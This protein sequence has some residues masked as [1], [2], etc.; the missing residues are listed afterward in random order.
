M[1][2][3][4]ILTALIR[5]SLPTAPLHGF[6]APA[7]GT[8]KSLLVDLASLIAT[9]HP[10]PVIAQGKSEEEMEKRLGAAL[11]AGDGLI[12]IDNCEQPLRGELLCQ[13]IS[14]TSLKVRILGKSMNAEVPS[15]AAIFATGNNLTLQG[16][17]TR[18]AVRATLDAG[19]ER[20][21]LRAFDRDPAAMVTAK[22]G[23]YVTASLT[24]LRAYHIAGRP[25]QTTPL[26]SFVDWSRWVRDALVWLG[27]A[28]PCETMESVR[29]SDPKLE[30]LTTVLTQWHA[31]IGDERVTVHQ[32]IDRATEKRSQLYDRSEFVHAEF[33]EA[34]LAIAGDGG[35]INGRRLGRWIGAH[36]NRIVA[37]LKLVSAGLSAGRMRWRLVAAES[38]APSINEVSET[39]PECVGA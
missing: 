6:N 39:V 28:D 18:R 7:A 27:E 22:R 32:L 12:A 38:G 1:A 26:G 23:D 33:R 9:A 16:D 37:G 36:Q 11:I 20:P 8:G 25:Q 19:V 29:G 2:L 15:N 4:G 14:Q 17:M 34:L 13:A 24:I 21:E 30:A 10:A 35:A 31:V 5:R 3:S